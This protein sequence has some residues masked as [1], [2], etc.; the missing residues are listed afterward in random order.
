MD[1][2]PSFPFVLEHLLTG[3]IRLEFLQEKLP[4]LLQDVPLVIRNGKY[5]HHDGYILFDQ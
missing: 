2:Q 3:Q 4:G 1:N 5:D